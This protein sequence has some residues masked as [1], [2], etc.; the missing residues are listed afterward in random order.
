MHAKNIQ[1]PALTIHD[2]VTKLP[3]VGAKISERLQRLHIHTVSDLLFHLPSR[4]IDRT[5]LY[6]IMSA[7]IAQDVVIQGQIMSS[8]YSPKLLSCRIRDDSGELTMRLFHFSPRQHQALKK[9]KTIRCFGMVRHGKQGREMVHP[10]FRVLSDPDKHPLED[11][12]TPVYPLTEGLTQ[13]KLRQ[14]SDHALGILDETAGAE[15]ELLPQELLPAPYAMDLADALRQVHRPSPGADIDSLLAGTTKAQKRMAYEELLTHHLSVKYIRQQNQTRQASRMHVNSVCVKNLLS[16]LPFQL[17]AAQQRAWNEIRRDLAQ[18]IPMMRLLQGDVGAG[19]TIVAAMAVLQVMDSNWQ[20]AWL[21]PTEMLAAQHYRN[22]REFLAA[23]GMPVYCLSGKMAAAERRE[24]LAAMAENKPL[25]VIGT[26]ALFQEKVKFG[27]LGLVIIDEQHRFGVQQRMRLLEKGSANN[28]SPH[29]LVMT[30]TPIPRTLNMTAYAELDCSIIDELPPGRRS[31]N[32]VLISNQRR[33]E[34]IQRIGHACGQRRQVYWV[35]KLIEESE[36]QSCEDVTNTWE[37][38]REKLPG[39]NIGLVHG[40]L[41]A[42]EKEQEMTRFRSGEYSVLVATTV[43][44]V[45][46][47]VPGASL[48]IIDNA[49]MFGLAQLHQLR[50]RVGRGGGQSDCVLMYQPPLSD[51]AKRRL[52]VLRETSDGF[53]IAEKDMELRG[54]GEVLGKRQTGQAEYRI[55]DLARDRDLLS[56]VPDA[57]KHVLTEHPGLSEA[58]IDRWLGKGADFSEV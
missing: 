24:A 19:K 53:V 56:G 51:V 28:F 2:P 17:T 20:V 45:G 40:K 35:C 32:T 4:Y 23:S 26:H 41:S 39:Q 57:A 5:R 49:E 54:P 12:L 6:P 22:V 21:A 14:L 16:D 44:E 50:G 13:Y 15:F 42:E 55:A 30:A 31:P 8:H 29:Q 10:E 18:T 33:D 58:L 34:V 11:T 9:G 27:R 38:L 36:A 47:D 25:L 1:V 7:E 43:I 48:M 46:V 37:E 52:Q 3:G